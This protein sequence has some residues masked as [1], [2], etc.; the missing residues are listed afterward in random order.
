ML[1]DPVNVLAH[2]WPCACLQFVSGPREL[3]KTLGFLSCIPVIDLV[4]K[5]GSDINE[6]KSLQLLFYFI[7]L[8]S[9]IASVIGISFF[10]CVSGF[11]LKFSRTAILTETFAIGFQK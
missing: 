2:C 5:K 8:M 4:L 9:T 6:G 10:S 3:D 11:R 1:M 7:V